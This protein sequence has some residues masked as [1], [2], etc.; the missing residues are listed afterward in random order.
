VD[1]SQIYDYDHGNY[2]QNG[3]DWDAHG[4]AQGHSQGHV[5]QGSGSSQQNSYYYG[6]SNNKRHDDDDDNGDMW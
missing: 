4:Q 3:E 2:Q 6:Q 1:D 5:R